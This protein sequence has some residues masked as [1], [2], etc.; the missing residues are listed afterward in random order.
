MSYDID[1]TKNLKFDSIYSG[2]LGLS[3]YGA[4]P[5]NKE[6]NFLYQL[7][8]KGFIDHMTFS[9]YVTLKDSFNNHPESSI[10]FGSY[11]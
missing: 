7:K 10:K 5:K 2:Y 4:D 9:F 6:Y 3:P 1:E 11:D 8:N